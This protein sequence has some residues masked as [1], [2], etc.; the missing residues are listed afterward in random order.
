MT[1]GGKT[2][3]CQGGIRFRGRGKKIVRVS[4]ASV[5]IFK[6]LPPPLSKILNTRLSAR[7]IFWL[8]SF[9]K[10]FAWYDIF[11]WLTF[12]LYLSLQ[13]YSKYFENLIRRRRAGKRM[14]AL[15]FLFTHTH[16]P[17]LRPRHARNCIDASRVVVVV[18]FLRSSRQYICKGLQLFIAL[19][20]NWRMMIAGNC[21]RME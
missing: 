9:L 19:K 17:I 4:R 15:I 12:S 5:F 13:C 16:K 3:L 21:A 18:A 6:I 8:P 20:Q 10:F 7:M 14:A 2:P 1:G 11:L